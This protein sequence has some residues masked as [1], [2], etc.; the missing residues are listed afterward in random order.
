MIKRIIVYG[1]SF[2]YGYELDDCKDCPSNLTYAALVAQHYGLEYEC[3]AVGAN[4]NQSIT[5]N[6]INSEILPTDLVMV[7]WTFIER[8]DFLFEGDIG[9][10][11]ISPGDNLPFAQEYYR[12]IDSDSDYVLYLTHKELLLTQTYLKST[13]APFL[14]LSVVDII[15]KSLEWNTRNLVPLIDKTKWIIPFGNQGFF[16]WAKTQNLLFQGH[17]EHANEHAHCVLADYII[18]QNLISK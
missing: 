6:I 11:S 3:R 13:Q 16:D 5:R 1:D 12:Y 4:A 17:S 2:T 15:Y 7:M 14:F 10:R 18:S 8:N 9:W